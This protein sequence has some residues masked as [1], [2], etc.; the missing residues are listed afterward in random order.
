MGRGACK[1]LRVYLL[2]AHVRTRRQIALGDSA[3]SCHHLLGEWTLVVLLRGL[4]TAMLGLVSQEH[5]ILSA[6]PHPPDR[7]CVRQEASPTP[8][9]SKLKNIT[10]R[11]VDCDRPF[12]VLTRVGACQR[13]PC[14]APPVEPGMVPVKLLREQEPVLLAH[15]G[16]KIE[17]LRLCLLFCVGALAAE[18]ALV[19]GSLHPP[20][21]P[22]SEVVD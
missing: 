15:L 17:L 7:W 5:Q 10:T 16:A 9:L 1:H 2:D 6:S 22:R 4:A 21:P 12:Y 13:A 8:R 3:Q 20:R 11:M 14:I 18:A 19:E